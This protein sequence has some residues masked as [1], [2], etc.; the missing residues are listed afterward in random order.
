MSKSY[1]YIVVLHGKKEVPFHVRWN[2][3]IEIR[4]SD[5][6][7]TDENCIVHLIESPV[8]LNRMVE[9]PVRCG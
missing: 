8:I 4:S 9:W 5:Y 1:Y 3:E 7:D 6:T 2:G